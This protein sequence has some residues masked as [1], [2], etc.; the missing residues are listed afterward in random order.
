MN[1]NNTNNTNTTVSTSTSTNAAGQTTHTVTLNTPPVT[2][3]PVLSIADRLKAKLN[4]SKAPADKTSNPITPKVMFESLDQPGT[5]TA[6]IEAALNGEDKQPLVI[7][8][9]HVNRSECLKAAHAAIKF[10]DLAAKYAPTYG[11][12]AP[13]FTR[14]LA[15]LIIQDYNPAT[16]EAETET[17]APAPIIEA[18]AAAPEAKQETPTAPAEKPGET[19]NI[20]GIETPATPAKPKKG[21]HK[22]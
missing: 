16:L 22:A 12:T 19:A 15:K 7:L 10:S 11:L 18:T 3:A 17:T 5:V 21:T 14:L 4:K 6:F 9:S 1:T 13:E 20:F 8:A 2:A